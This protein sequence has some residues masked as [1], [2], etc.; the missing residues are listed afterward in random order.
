[1]LDSK[2]YVWSEV[3]TIF[4]E[5]DKYIFERKMFEEEKDDEVET[6]VIYRCEASKV[7]ERLN[8]MGFT[9]Q[10][11]RKEFEEIRQA[12]IEKY[13]KWTL[14][15]A[16]DSFIENLN[17]Y[18]KLTFD[19]YAQC[20]KHIL[21]GDVKVDYFDYKAKE[22]LD[23]I[24]KHI[25]YNEDYHFGFLGRCVRSF[26]R[27]ACE[28]VAPDSA[29]IQ[30]ITEL[31]ANGYYEK[32]EPVCQNAII[33]L[34]SR[35]PE[36]SLRIIL[37][38]GSTDKEILRESLLLLYPHLFEYYSFLEFSAT[39]SQGGAGNLVT[40]IKAFA[41]AGITNRIIAIFDNDSAAFDARRSLE[42]INLP[43]NIAICNY[44]NF[45]QL[46]NYPTI[47]PGGTSCLNVNGLAASIE[48]YLG[49]DV[50]MNES[51]KF[52]VQWKGFVDSLG[53][54]QGEV[55]HKSKI[56]ANYKKKIERCRASKTDMEQADWVG[57]KEIWNV[58]FKAFD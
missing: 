43:Q 55:M 32:D 24:T 26:L 12:E 8:V 50:L 22:T 10:R 39:R 27:L 58:I 6:A 3:M 31:V 35:H 36:N 17:F 4:R 52:P 51:D 37:T 28:V 5:T 38:E 48:L 13:T 19:D 11:I 18:K 1:M 14:D 45:K 33:S 46:E 53:K 25:E 49:E 34:T 44:P 57:L 15:D 47:G 20:L 56:H 41:A 30:D 54:Y 40:I 9:M 2:S 29:I 23:P 21:T 7:I 16:H 42:S